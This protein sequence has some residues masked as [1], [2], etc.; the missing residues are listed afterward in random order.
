MTVEEFLRAYRRRPRRSLYVWLF[1]ALKVIAGALLGA[2]IQYLTS[3]EWSPALT[4]IAVLVL[5][6]I[7][8]VL[9]VHREHAECIATQYSDWRKT[10]PKPHAG[11]IVLLSPYAPPARSVPLPKDIRQAHEQFAGVTDFATVDLEV[12]GKVIDSSNLR[13]PVEA[14]SYHL[15][16]G[17]L[18]YVWALTSRQPADDPNA[19]HSAPVFEIVRAWFERNDHR[20]EFQKIEVDATDYGGIARAVRN[21][22]CDAQLRPKQIVCDFTGMT[23]PMSFAAAG[24]AASAGAKLQYCEMIRRDWTGQPRFGEQLNVGMLEATKMFEFIDTDEDQETSP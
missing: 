12:M 7:L 23:K 11:L 1:D 16:D 3:A 20:L 9:L 4:T 5:V 22:I 19:A 6:G 18:K 24:A 17:T 13:P 8:V 2:A 21:L 15:R 14:I 10:D